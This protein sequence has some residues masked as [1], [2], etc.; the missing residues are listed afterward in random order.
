MV[1]LYSIYYDKNSEGGMAKVDL[2]AGSQ[3]AAK[4]IFEAN[5]GPNRN[6]RIYLIRKATTEETEGIE[7]TGAPSPKRDFFRI[8]NHGR[9]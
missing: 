2:L 9:K 8:F 3:E 1:F 6:P 4:R 5:F 7:H